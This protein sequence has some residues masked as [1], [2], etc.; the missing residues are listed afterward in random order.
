MVRSPRGES[1]GPDDEKSAVVPHQEVTKRPFKKKPRRKRALR[2]RPEVIEPRR[3]RLDTYL[4]FD[5]NKIKSTETLRKYRTG[6]NF[7]WKNENARKILIASGFKEPGLYESSNQQGG[8]IFALPREV[9]CHDMFGEEAAGFVMRHVLKSGATRSQCESVSKLL[10]YIWQLQTGEAGGNFK[11]VR[12]TWKRHKPEDFGKPTQRV[13]AIY[14][15]EP[16]HLKT[17]LTTEWTQD[18]P[19]KYHVWSLAYLL[20]FDWCVLGCR[21]KVDLGKIKNSS[22][23]VLAPGQGFMYTQLKDGRAK[24][25]GTQGTR[26]WK[27]YR[28]CMCPDEKHNGPPED[29]LENIIVDEEN[30]AWCTTCPISCAQVIK[31]LLDPQDPRL[32]PSVTKNQHFAK[33]MGAEYKNMGAKSIFKFAREFLTNQGGN[34]DGLTYDT[35]MGRKA[36]GKLCEVAN[37]SYMESFEIHGDL[38]KNWRH[39][40]DTITNDKNFTRRTQSADITTCLKGL[41]KIVRWFGRGRTRR[42]DPKVFSNRQIGELMALVGRKLGLNEEVNRILDA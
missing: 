4:A 27:A 33:Y 9:P 7:A 28:V 35:N 31:A 26:P 10:S 38:F 23:H 18:N 29:F 17:A 24:I 25:E 19:M 13:K 36:L 2:D 20:V 1:E 14:V 42:E 11:K 32:Y 16:E 34:P 40:Q 5:A 22:E 37:V 6:F 8:K 15:I 41:R 21:P 12:Q 30:P 3:A 39:Y